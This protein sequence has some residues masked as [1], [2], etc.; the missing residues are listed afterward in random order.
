[1]RPKST[2]AGTRPYELLSIEQVHYAQ[3]LQV[4]TFV[5]YFNTRSMKVPSVSCSMQVVMKKG[6]KQSEQFK[7]LGMVC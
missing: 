7:G 6:F 1:M 4:C 2:E 3:S 5:P